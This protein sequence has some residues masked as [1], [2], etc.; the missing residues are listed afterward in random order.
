MTSEPIYCTV[1]RVEVFSRGPYN[2][3][4]DLAEINYAITDGDCIG[5]CER[6]S[7]AIVP[8]EK[9]DDELC[10]IGNDGTFFDDGEFVVF[11]DD[12]QGACILTGNDGENPDDCT[13]H[14]HESETP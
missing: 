8:P 4:F 9:L 6:I 13:T 11:D 1:F 2:D 5:N 10:R 14:D 7:S 12:N 3:P